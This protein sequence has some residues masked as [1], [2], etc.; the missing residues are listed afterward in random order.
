PLTLTETDQDKVMFQ[1]T[2]NNPKD[3]ETPVITKDVE[4]KESLEVEHEK[5]YKYNVKTQIPSDLQGYKD[6][7]ISDTLDNRLVLVSATVLVD[8]KDTGLKVDVNGNDAKLTL[9]R[10]Q[11]NLIAGKEVNLQITAKIKDGTP[12]EVIDNIANI[13]LNDKPSV[14]SNKV[15]VTPPTPI[16]PVITKDVEGKEHLEVETEKSYNYNVKSKIADDV[17]GYK[18]LTISDTLDKRL[19]IVST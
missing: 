6:L 9:T 4:G 16:K 1:Y 12:I 3:P 11:L 19:D 7:T 10:E 18:T 15:Q 14:N 8:G 5:E 13:Q 2:F 17:R